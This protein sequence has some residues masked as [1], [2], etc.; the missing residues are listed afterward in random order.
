M[1]SRSY[2]DTTTPL[3]KRLPALV[4]EDPR[5]Q[6]LVQHGFTVMSDDTARSGVFLCVEDF[7]HQLQY[8][9]DSL[10]H[11]LAQINLQ[12]NA[13]KRQIVVS[14]PKPEI[15]QQIF[16][17]K[18]FASFSDRD[19][20][21]SELVYLGSV[22]NYKGDL[23]KEVLDRIHS[24]RRA[25]IAFGKFWCHSSI[26]QKF[27]RSVFMAVVRSSLLVGLEAAVLTREQ[28]D[29]LES[30][31]CKYMRKILCGQACLK[32]H[33]INALGQATTRFRALPNDR[34]RELLHIPTVESELLARRLSWLQTMT[35][36][37]DHAKGMLSAL[38]GF[39]LWESQP[40]ITPDGLL[41][42][43]SNPWTRQFY[44]DL[45]FA[46]KHGSSEFASAWDR[47]HWWSIFSD[48]FQRVA[49]KRL[50]RFKCLQ[51]EITT[52]YGILAR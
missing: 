23:H 4:L 16:S 44:S 33:N 24:A 42:A 32:L 30:Q 51:H 19:K 2:Y 48:E 26:H 15:S 7:L 49:P 45:A 25:W 12:Q 13:A 38:H 35:R 5:S 18:D 36:F 20:F 8:W 10:D 37:P 27:R 11:H 50:K 52:F 41:T 14:T 31:Q 43:I 46:A 28:V 9:S 39:A 22:I 34:V 17:S 21:V 40:T 47:S 6:E 3:T 1:A 29:A